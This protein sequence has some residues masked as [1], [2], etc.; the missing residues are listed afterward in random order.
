MQMKC[1]KAL[2]NQNNLIKPFI[3][4]WINIFLFALD[5]SVHCFL[6]SVLSPLDQCLP[7]EEKSED[8][9]ELL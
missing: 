4:I 6:L 8:A 7:M 5:P 1:G 3:F 9:S 2:C